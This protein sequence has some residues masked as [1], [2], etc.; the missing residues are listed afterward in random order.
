MNVFVVPSVASRRVERSPPAI[1][2]VLVA[3]DLSELGNRAIPH[4]LALLPNGGVL[5][6]A[7]V[8]TPAPPATSM[9]DLFP[10]GP[11]DFWVP[12]KDVAARLERLVPVEAAR[13]GI[14]VQAHVLEGKVPDALCAAAERLAVDVVCLTSRARRPVHA[15]VAGSTT[16]GVLARSRRPVF[17]VREP[18]D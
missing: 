1:R 8:W 18:E 14:S 5:H 2:E 11:R 13:K 10:G 17:V 9:P 15:T 3:T 4:A 16:L 7:H 6:L 12:A